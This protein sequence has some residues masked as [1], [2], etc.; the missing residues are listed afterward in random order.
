MKNR[1]K[2]L[3][4]LA[5]VL[6]SFQN[7]QAAVYADALIA[8]VPHVLQKPDFCGEACAEM[9][10]RKK[11]MATTQD[12]I[13]NVSDLDP[14]QGRGCYTAELNVA[15]TKIGFKTGDVWTQVSNAKL[16]AE[17]ETQWQALHSDLVKGVPSIVCM[18]YDDKPNTT[19]HF[20]LALGYDSKTDEVIYHE[21][22]VAKAAYQRMKRAKWIKLWPLKNN[23]Q[24]STAIRLRLDHGTLRPVADNPG[25]SRADFAQHILALREKLPAGFNI[26]VQP[27][28]VV[29]GDEPPAVVRDHTINTV[30]WAVDR[31]KAD[32]FKN[33]PK[34]ILNIWLFKNSVSYNNHNKLLFGEAPSTPYGYYSPADKALVMNIETGG[35]TLVHEIV[36]PFMAAN[37]PECPPWFNEGMGSLYE[38]CGEENGRIVGHTNWRLPGLQKALQADGVPTFKELMEMNTRTFY[39]D[40][41]G[42]NY[43]QSRYLCY[44]LQQQGLLVKYASEFMKSAKD[45]PSGYKTLQK[46]LGT[47]DMTA[48]QK[49]WN[50]FVMKLRF[51]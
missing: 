44:Y 20:R 48:F 14:A 25:F 19:E 27:P 7:A 28:F 11:G 32:Y 26:V 35:G 24:T 34:D 30:K 17:L 8:D 22:A 4:L 3:L 49:K 10:L 18:H 38:Q 5:V 23:E 50:G 13:F 31:L 33:D 16:A 46:I 39:N 9:Y 40:E 42:T 43:G 21:P 37:F 51:P 12:Q 36:H 41:H 29:I 6:C 15:L 47:E 45:D 2:S 1:L